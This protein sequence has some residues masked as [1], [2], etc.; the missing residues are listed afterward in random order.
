VLEEHQAPKVVSEV[1][2]QRADAWARTR[3]A[4]IIESR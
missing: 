3:A 1:A 4:E 2:L